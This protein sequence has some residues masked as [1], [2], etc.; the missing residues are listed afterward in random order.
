MRKGIEDRV[1]ISL[2][3]AINGVELI[4]GDAAINSAF[5]Y[6]RIGRIQVA[7]WQANLTLRSGER[8]GVSLH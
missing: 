5:E 4:A 3:W 2:V 6:E 1:G 8:V 7:G